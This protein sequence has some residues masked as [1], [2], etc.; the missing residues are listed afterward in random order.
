MS[1]RSPEPPLTALG[2][3]QAALL[4]QQL[5]VA[6]ARP[7]PES[8]RMAWLV[9]EH[10]IDSLYVSPM[11]RAMQTAEPIGRA[12]GLAPQVWVDIHEHGGV[13]T[14]NPDKANVVEYPGLSRAQMAAQFPAYQILGGVGDGG[15][16]RGGY[17]ELGACY[18]RAQ[19]V[20]TALLA[21]AVARP[22]SAVA[23]VT[24]GT[25]LD[26]LFHALLAPGEA[27]NDCVHFSNLNT[28]TSR[29][30]FHEGGHI[31]LRYLNRVDHLP[32]ELVTR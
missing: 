32:V 7:L 9:T 20:A 8:E 25:F 21:M 12:L 1:T 15:W 6:A 10:P 13:F 2:H 18:A 4:A 23:L 17:E 29:V 14:G 19:R 31:S 11:L 27:Y 26:N 28:A 30:D 22:D 16:W 5:A 24:H 3:R